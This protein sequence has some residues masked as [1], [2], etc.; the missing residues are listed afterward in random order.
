MTK[1][2]LRASGVSK[3]VQTADHD[4]TILEDVS[5]E[6]PAGQSVAIIGPSG[7]GKSTLLGL[8]AGLDTPSTG[9]IWMGEHEITATNEEGRAAIRAKMVGFVFQTFQLLGSL[10]ALENVSLPMELAGEKNA[11]KRATDYLDKVGLAARLKHYPKQLSGG[12]Q[13]RV[14]IARAFACEPKILFA[15]EPTGNLDQATGLKISDLLFDMN[16][17][18]DTTLVLVTHEQR[19]A[20]RCQSIVTIDDGRLVSHL[21]NKSGGQD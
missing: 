2:I 17:Q 3:R 20:E 4:L 11:K 18:S 16:Q 19:L 14:A 1:S 6:V 10:T 12:E 9:S 5:F 15:D 21:S 8:L 13:Q 7:A